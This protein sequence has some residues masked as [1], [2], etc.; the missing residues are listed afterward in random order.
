MSQFRLSLT[1]VRQELGPGRR[2]GRHPAG[3]AFS[4]TVGLDTNFR[5][6]VTHIDLLHL[7]IEHPRDDLIL[8]SWPAP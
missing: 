2:N 5:V 6:D 7:P 3:Q 4:P 1:M 8:A